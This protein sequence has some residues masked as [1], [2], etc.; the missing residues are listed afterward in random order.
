MTARCTALA[1]AGLA[2]SMDTSLGNRKLPRRWPA[3]A[4]NGAWT[5]AGD[6]APAG[7]NMAVFPFPH[8]VTPARM[9]TAN[10]AADP[11]RRRMVPPWPP[12]SG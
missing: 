1:G 11:H 7:W 5:G 10:N 3:G 12:G 6:R 9:P 8:A 2:K 4:G